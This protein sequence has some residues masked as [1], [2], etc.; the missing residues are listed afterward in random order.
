[1]ACKSNK[2]CHQIQKNKGTDREQKWDNFSNKDPTVDHEE[3]R[4]EKLSAQFTIEVSVPLAVWT[5]NIQHAVCY[6]INDGRVTGQLWT[7]WNLTV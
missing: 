3:E 1:M 2:T 4:A 5:Y 6:E 7:Y